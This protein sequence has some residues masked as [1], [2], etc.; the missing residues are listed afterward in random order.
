MGCVSVLLIIH[1]HKFNLLCWRGSE[2]EFARINYEYMFYVWII[3]A[4][5]NLKQDVY[6]LFW[7]ILQILICLY[8]SYVRSSRITGPLKIKKKSGNLKKVFLY[9]KTL[10][11]LLNTLL[12]LASRVHQ[13]YLQLSLLEVSGSADKHS[14][15]V[16]GNISNYNL[17]IIFKV[18]V[19]K[20][21]GQKRSRDFARRA[22]FQQQETPL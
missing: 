15:E 3:L 5:K 1:L 2:N 4:K 7:I 22:I 16:S 6:K 18:K 12:R 8:G 19:S 14:S 21:I 17:T 9:Q 13:V 11:F 20:T 10:T